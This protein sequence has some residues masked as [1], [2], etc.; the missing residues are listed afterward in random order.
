[1]SYEWRVVQRHIP[2]SHPSEV[3]EGDVVVPMNSEEQAYGRQVFLDGLF[4]DGV[5]RVEVVRVECRELGPWEE[6]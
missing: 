3:A 1:M 5:R 2:P 4:A 6:R